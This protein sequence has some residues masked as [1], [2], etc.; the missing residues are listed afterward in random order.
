MRHSP[1]RPRPRGGRHEPG[2]AAAHEPGAAAGH[3]PG[4]TRR[5]RPSPRAP[6]FR[7]CRAGRG[8]AW[9]ILEV[10]RTHSTL[11]FHQE[12]SFHDHESRRR[13][14]RHSNHTG[15]TRMVAVAMGT[16]L[17]LRDD[18]RTGIV[19]VDIASSQRHCSRAVLLLRRRVI[20]SPPTF[21]VGL[22]WFESRRRNCTYCRSAFSASEASR[23][24]ARAVACSPTAADR[25]YLVNHLGL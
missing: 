7:K 21:G 10:S 14:A 18:R 15:H 3:E 1:R 20:G 4:P 5:G 16:Y 23:S 25:V 24:R 2:A 22:S 8:C 6:T 12:K 13:P 17:H 19:G 11:F 9:K